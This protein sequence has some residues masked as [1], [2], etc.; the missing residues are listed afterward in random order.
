MKVEP[1]TIAV[2]EYPALSIE[3]PVEVP[4][5]NVI[6]SVSG[7]V[8]FKVGYFEKVKDLVPIHLP[9]N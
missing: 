2:S 3:M 4:V 1:L 9:T 6:V 5:I 7:T 8:L